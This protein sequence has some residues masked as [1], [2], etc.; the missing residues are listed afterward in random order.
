MDARLVFSSLLR[1]VA[2]NLCFVIAVAVAALF[3]GG[4]IPF[5]AAC[6]RA[7]L[8]ASPLWAR[9]LPV[10]RARRETRAA[11]ASSKM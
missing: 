8:F 6:C 2:G 4:R 11:T 3:Q 1:K 9:L 10:L 7:R 5:G